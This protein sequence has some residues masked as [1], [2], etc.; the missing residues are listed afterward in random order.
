MISIFKYDTH[1]P[2]KWSIK[3]HAYSSNKIWRCFKFVTASDSANLISFLSL[4]RFEIHLFC[5]HPTPKYCSLLQSPASLRDTRYTVSAMPKFNL[6]GIAAG[7]HNVTMIVKARNLLLHPIQ[8]DDELIFE[9]SSLVYFSSCALQ[10]HFGILSFSFS[11][12]MMFARTSNRTC[13]MAGSSS[14]DNLTS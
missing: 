3:L 5:I 11:L 1:F 12:D 2:I 14:S 7:V 8:T 6:E 13:S 9:T 4:E 10:K